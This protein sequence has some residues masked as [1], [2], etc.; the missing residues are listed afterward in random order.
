M[1]DDLIMVSISIKP[2]QSSGTGV[3]VKQ[4]EF[5]GDI[6]IK[7]VRAGGGTDPDPKP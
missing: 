7:G 1:I 4:G 6:A 3:K 5:S 2:Q